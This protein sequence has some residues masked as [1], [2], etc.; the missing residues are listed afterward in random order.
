M[1]ADHL[2]PQVLT[3]THHKYGTPWVSIVFLAAVNALLVRWGFADAHRRS[4]SS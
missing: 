2:L 4:T 3:R 1:A